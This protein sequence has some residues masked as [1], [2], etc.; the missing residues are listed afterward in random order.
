MPKPHQE[1]E[2]LYLRFRKAAFEQI[3]AIASRQGRERFIRDVVAKALKR[4]A[5]AARRRARQ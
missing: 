3:D 5:A 2:M 4:A 1:I